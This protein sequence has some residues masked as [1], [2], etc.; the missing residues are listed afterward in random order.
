MSPPDPLAELQ[1]RLGHDFACPE[2]LAQGVTHRSWHNEHL[3]E[4]SIGDYERLEFLG[5]AALELMITEALFRRHA[6][7]PEGDLTR[8][9]A[10]LVNESAL[11][12]LARALGLPEALRLGRGEDV[13]GGRNK[14]S[15]LSDAFEAV[16]G[17][18][19]LDAGYDRTFHLIL[20]RFDPALADAD[21]NLDHK[22]RLQA[23]VQTDGGPTPTYVTVGESGP[24][25]EKV[26]EVALVLDGEELARGV[27]RSKKDASLAAARRGLSRLAP[28]DPGEDG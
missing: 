9:R 2:L 20:P 27:G 24:D 5:D 18:L 14:D 26:F 19:F 12:T 1:A 7:L 28:Q 23:L 16:V 3:H 6:E 22:S 4:G 21:R 8:M 11:A 17:A 15:I 13:S 10:A 25:H